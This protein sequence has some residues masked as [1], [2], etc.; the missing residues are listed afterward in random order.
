[1]TDF[2][3]RNAAAKAAKTAAYLRA[4]TSTPALVET[5]PVA[6]QAEP[7]ATAEVDPRFCKWG[8]GR[9]R[10]RGW[11]ECRSCCA[12]NDRRSQ[13]GLGPTGPRVQ[14]RNCECGAVAVRNGDCNKCSLRKRRNK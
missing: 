1:M 3:Q 2:E 11:P 6:V 10:Q 12:R 5:L 13:A 8:C 4:T 7:F 14:N 9:E